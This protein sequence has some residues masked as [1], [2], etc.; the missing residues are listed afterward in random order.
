MSIIYINK[1]KLQ[2]KRG[3]S[4][5]LFTLCSTPD[6]PTPFQMYPYSHSQS[7]SLRSAF[8]CWS[9]GKCQGKNLR[10]QAAPPHFDR[11]KLKRGW[12]TEKWTTSS[13]GTTSWAKVV[14]CPSLMNFMNPSVRSVSTVKKASRPGTPWNRSSMVRSDLFP[15]LPPVWG[16]ITCARICPAAGTGNKRA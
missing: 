6:P 15:K 2:T 8:G 13:F 10:H 5:Y 11:M 12:N 7:M 9:E 14:F 1:V 3:K 16:L 4:K